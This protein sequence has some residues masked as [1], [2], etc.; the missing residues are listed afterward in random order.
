MP[1]MIGIAWAARDSS[2]QVPA[3]MAASTSSWVTLGSCQTS[4]CLRLLVSIVR[5]MKVPGSQG[6]SCV[7]RAPGTLP[8]GTALSVWP[9]SSLFATLLFFCA[10]LGHFCQREQILCGILMPTDEPDGPA[11][12]YTNWHSPC[13]TLASSLCPRQHPVLKTLSF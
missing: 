5:M 6:S 10:Y 8:T 2:C 7:P 11:N 1:T 3:P 12:R 4:L 9:T 13:T